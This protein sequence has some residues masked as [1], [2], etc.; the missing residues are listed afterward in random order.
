[1][2]NIA[3]LSAEKMEDRQLEYIDKVKKYRQLENDMRAFNDSL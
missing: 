1:M 2:A 3:E